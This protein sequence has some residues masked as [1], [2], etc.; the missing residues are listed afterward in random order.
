MNK[1]LYSNKKD[2]TN[3]PYTKTRQHTQQYTKQQELE[4]IQAFDSK[5]PL[6][7]NYTKLR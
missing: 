4:P 7:K 1:N 2:N 5:Q 3:R 6:S